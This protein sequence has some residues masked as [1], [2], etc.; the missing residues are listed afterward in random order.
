MPPR[1]TWR[2][3]QPPPPMP[4]SLGSR[5]AETGCPTLRTASVPASQWQR[6]PSGRACLR[7]LTSNTA[8]PALSQRKLSKH[9][10][11][12]TENRAQTCQVTQT[13]TTSRLGRTYLHCRPDWVPNSKTH[14]SHIPVF[15]VTGLFEIQ[16]HLTWLHITGAVYFHR[17]KARPSTSNWLYCRSPELHWRSLRSASRILPE[18]WV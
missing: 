11:D 18:G 6:R 10:C 1:Q 3:P 4:S 7:F 9:F 17:L 16:A 15:R 5:T 14:T 8:T 12:P 13:P 2:S